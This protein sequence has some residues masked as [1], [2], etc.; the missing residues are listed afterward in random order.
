MPTFITVLALSPEVLPN[1]HAHAYLI[2]LA[3]MGIVGGLEWLIVFTLRATGEVIEEWDR[4]LR[5]LDSIRA[6]RQ[7]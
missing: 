5:K 6:R 1:L 3:V 7:Q 2:G 4:F